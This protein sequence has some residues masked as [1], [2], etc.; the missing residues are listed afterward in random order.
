MLLT[1][2]GKNRIKHEEEE[3]NCEKERK[4]ERNV[5]ILE[6]HRLNLRRARAKLGGM[7]KRR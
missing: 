3:A 4:K 1:K 6:T 7:W 5:K 2:F